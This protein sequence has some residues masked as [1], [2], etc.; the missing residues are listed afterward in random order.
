MHVFGLF[1][2]FNNNT[3]FFCYFQENLQTLLSEHTGISDD[4]TNRLLSLG[5]ALLSEESKALSIPDFPID[6]LPYILKIMVSS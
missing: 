6:N 1:C 3:F 4:A 5:Y 2:R